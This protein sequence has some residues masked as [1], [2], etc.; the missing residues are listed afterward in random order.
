MYKRGVED[1]PAPEE[2]FTAAPDPRAV[3]DKIFSPGSE[4]DYAMAQAV[5]KLSKFPRERVIGTG[6]R[7]HATIV[8]V[9]RDSRGSGRIG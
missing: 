5:L 2:F 9:V 8:P 4:I 3:Y 7:S 6:G 1:I